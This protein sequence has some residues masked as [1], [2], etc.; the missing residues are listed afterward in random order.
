MVMVGGI[1]VGGQ[2]VMEVAVAGDVAHEVAQRDA[3]IGGG[4]HTAAG[5]ARGLTDLALPVSLDFEPGPITEAESED[6]GGQ[7]VGMLTQLAVMKLRSRA[8]HGTQL[9]AHDAVT[10]E[11]GREIIQS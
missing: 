3:R 11:D 10:H 9:D 7:A 6:V 8:V 2:D 4:F 5:T 1:V